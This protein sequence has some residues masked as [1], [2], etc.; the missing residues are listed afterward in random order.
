MRCPACG[1]EEY[2]RL[3]YAIV[4]CTRCMSLYDPFVFPGFPSTIEEAP[5]GTKW[6]TGQVSRDEFRKTQFGF[7]YKFCSICHSHYHNTN[8]HTTCI[9]CGSHEHSTPH[10]QTC[11][12]CGSHEHST[13][14][15]WR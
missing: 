11:G 9:F 10:H 5:V 8:G 1:N 2:E 13:D 6:N 3:D 15:H 4:R 7:D 14:N 12:H